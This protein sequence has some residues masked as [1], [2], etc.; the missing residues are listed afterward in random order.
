MQS[1]VRL[2]MRSP[3]KWRATATAEQSCPTD[4]ACTSADYNVEI[5]HFK[6]LCTCAALDGSVDLLCHKCNAY[7][8][9]SVSIQR[10]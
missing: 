3:R 10:T 6:M 9:A 5:V 1:K 2:E 4:L 7:E 8:Q